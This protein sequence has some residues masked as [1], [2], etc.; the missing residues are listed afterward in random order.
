MCLPYYKFRQR[1][2]VLS[3]ISHGDN[4]LRKYFKHTEYYIDQVERNG[5]IMAMLKVYRYRNLYRSICKS[6]LSITINQ[7]PVFSAQKIFFSVL[8]APIE[9]VLHVIWGIKKCLF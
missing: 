2:E 5:T 3:L 9:Q 4:V 1:Y 6:G 7:L 8:T